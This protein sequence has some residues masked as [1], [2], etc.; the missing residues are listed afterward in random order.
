MFFHAAVKFQVARYVYHR[1]LLTNHPHTRFPFLY[2]FI[3]PQDSTQ[4]DY[5]DTDINETQQ[6]G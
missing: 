4:D 3:L 1:F 2:I 6:K 5:Y